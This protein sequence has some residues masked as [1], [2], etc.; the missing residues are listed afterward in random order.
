M[1]LSFVTRSNTFGVTNL[2]IGIN[3]ASNEWHQIALTHDPTN[4]SIYVDGVPLATNGLGVFYFPD[5]SARSGGF[6][7]GSTKTGVNQ[8]RGRFDELTTFNYPLATEEIAIK[9][10]TAISADGDGDGLPDVWEF[11]YFGN[12]SADP[13]ADPDGDY[14][15][16]I[17]EYRA[18][19]NPKIADT[20]GDGRTDWQEL[21]DGTDPLNPASKATWP[22]VADQPYTPTGSPPGLRVFTQAGNTYFVLE[23]GDP[24]LKYDL[25]GTDDNNTFYWMG[26]LQ[27]N[28]RSILID[29][30]KARTTYRLDTPGTS[31][32]YHYDLLNRL[33]DKDSHPA[34]N[35]DNEGNIQ[36]ITP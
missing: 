1:S 8:A 5:A 25:Y 24:N 22:V 33:Q 21:K 34:Y 7:I 29:S 36:T 30:S 4:S 2:T 6:T 35:Y 20:D 31:A 16:N 15:T 17:E 28:V 11:S 27:M 19:T 23:T 13:N 32:N 10:K 26:R 9:Y 12:L 14:L 18:G 3:W